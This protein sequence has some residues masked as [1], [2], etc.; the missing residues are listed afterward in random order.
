MDY[1]IAIRTYKRSDIIQNK[2]L[3]I[4]NENNIPINKI[5]IFCGSDEIDI[6]K[7]KLNNNYTIVD[8]GS[9]GTNYCNLQINN[10]FDEGTYIIQMDDDINFILQFKENNN[11]R[12]KINGRIEPKNLEC[13]NLLSIIEE[14]KNLMDLHKFNLW[15]MYAVPNEFFMRKV[16]PI[17]YDLRFIIGRVFGFIN[18]K[19]IRTKDNCRDDYERTILYY[20][21]DGGVIRFNKY[22]CDADTYVGKGGL[23]ESRTVQK[24]EESVQYMLTT[25]PEYV[26]RKKTKS[27]YPEIRL[28]K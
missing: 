23:A 22:S 14:G 20:K 28:I 7:N 9:K 6:Y 2:T 15:G 10:Y 21:K 25:Y 8:G 5:F 26:K 12:K 16:A 13:A 4:L 19:Q 17:T 18:C 27:K 11:P 3:R 24:M 1:V